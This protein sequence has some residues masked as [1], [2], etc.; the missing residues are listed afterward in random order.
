MM[1]TYE[2]SAGNVLTVVNETN[3]A[4]MVCGKVEKFSWEE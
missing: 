1:S 2:V 3:N 4:T